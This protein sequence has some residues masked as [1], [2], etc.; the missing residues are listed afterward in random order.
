MS[1]TIRCSR[2]ITYISSV[3]SCRTVPLLIKVSS[4]IF[5]YKENS[6][7]IVIFKMHDPNLIET[8]IYTI[9]HY[10]MIITTIQTSC[11]GLTR[12]Q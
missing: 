6:I 12:I 9:I 11:Q 8:S 5:R 3:M 1:Q 10:K 4:S 7:E 2:S